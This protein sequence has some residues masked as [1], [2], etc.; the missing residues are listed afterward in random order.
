MSRPFFSR[1]LFGFY[2]RVVC[3]CVF[4]T[5]YFVLSLETFGSTRSDG[6]A[7]TRVFVCAGKALTQMKSGQDTARFNDVPAGRCILRR[8]KKI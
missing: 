3:V 7:R 4:L 8:G 1:T 2:S 5:T 6:N